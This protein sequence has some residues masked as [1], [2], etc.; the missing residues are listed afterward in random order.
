MDDHDIPVLIAQSGDRLGHRWHL[1]QWRVVI[2]RD[3][4]C[5]V[6][7]E[8]KVVS[9]QHACIY[10]EQ[11]QWILEDSSKN[12]TQINEEPVIAKTP[13]NDGDIISIATAVRLAFVGSDATVPLSLDD[14]PAGT[15]GR[16][17]VDS[18]ARRVWIRGQEITPPLSVAQYHLLELLYLRSEEVCSREEVV[19]AVWPDD[20]GVGVSEQ[21]IDALV[22]R[23]RDRLAEAD[24]VHQ[25]VVTVRGHGFRID[26]PA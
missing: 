15:A 3:P 13:V 11:D 1:T 22:R 14:A 10:R 19:H 16:L 20:D 24:P 21:S 2:G 9:R 12:G 25:Y 6:I 4:V 18:R 8:D 5:D 17:R 26:N 23:L 7:I